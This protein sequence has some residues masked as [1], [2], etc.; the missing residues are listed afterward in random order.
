MKTTLTTL[1]LLTALSSLTA[2]DGTETTQKLPAGTAPNPAQSDPATD[3]ATDPVTV[4]PGDQP[5]SVVDVAAYEK[6]PGIM[7]VRPENWTRGGEKQMRLAT[8]VPPAEFTGAE[9]AIAQWPGD[10]GGFDSNILR[11][12]GQV[13]MKLDPTSFASFELA[14]IDGSKATYI[15]LVNKDLNKAVLAYWVPRGANPDQPNETWTFKLT[16]NADQVDKLEPAFKA[17]AAS[18]K[19]E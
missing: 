6:A 8:L 10:V 17:W 4:Q 19:F 16:C 9:L 1:I 18:V 14:D 3:T 2:C 5:A 15:P 7:W 13:G 11:W 12:A